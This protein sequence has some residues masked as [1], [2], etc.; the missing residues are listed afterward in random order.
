MKKAVRFLSLALVMAMM[1]A[2]FCPAAS[3]ASSKSKAYYVSLGDSVATGYGL[4]EK[5]ENGNLVRL[6]IRTLGRKVEGS[7][8]VLLASYLKLTDEQF[9]N[10]SREGLSSIEFRRLF[11]KNYA[12]PE[13]EKY[14][15]DFL[16][17]RY[18]GYPDAKPVLDKDGNL[19]SYEV[20]ASTRKRL[21]KDIKQAKLMTV[22][23]GANDI[24]GYT[25]NAVSTTLAGTGYSKRSK[26]RIETLDQMQEQVDKLL[27]QGR[28][29]EALSTMMGT[30]K[31][32]G[33]YEIALEEAAEAL[34]SGMVRFAVNW[35]YV[36]NKIQNLNPNVKIAAIGI[37]NG[38]SGFFL[39]DA[40]LIDLGN[41]MQPVFT[42]MNTYME[43]YCRTHKNVEYI[44]IDGVAIHPYDSLLTTIETGG[45]A[46]L[47]LALM[48]NAHPTAEGHKDICKRIIKALEL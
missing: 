10:W 4:Y 43:S 41:L 7:Y 42:S 19:I 11:D 36:M 26:K 28:P 24:F 13:D 39:T 5:D 22:N 25:M 27:A 37:L 20:S 46:E 31:Q 32:L 6:G 18:G 34:S 38:I 14:H 45:Y 17:N 8:P 40:N 29:Q 33:L 35:T 9:V 47:S 2:L 30:A 15:S 21:F 1:M 16:L 48:L 12:P 23:F 44:D 3:A